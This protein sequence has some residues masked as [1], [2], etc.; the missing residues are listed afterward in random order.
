MLFYVPQQRNAHAGD[1]DTG[2]LISIKIII[3]NCCTILICQ[4]YK[5]V[6]FEKFYE[7]DEI[8]WFR[9]DTT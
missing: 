5:A 9:R 8:S 1:F 7:T 6:D 4:G 3:I 2:F